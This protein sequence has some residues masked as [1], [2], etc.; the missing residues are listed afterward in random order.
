M[1]TLIIL[2]RILHMPRIYT[3]QGQYYED[4]EIGDTVVSAGRTL[5]ESDVVAF[6]GVSGD[7]S[8]LHTN[9]E[10][11]RQGL[12]GERIAHGLLGISMASGLLTQLGFIEGT[13]LA[14]RE[15]TWKFKRP[16]VIGDTIRAEAVVTETRAMRRL[17][18]GTVTL[19][20]QVMNQ[21]NKVVQCGTWVLLVASRPAQILYQDRASSRSKQVSVSRQVQLVQ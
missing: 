15:M 1:T 13:V 21:I 2:E 4:F 10:F 12:F 5:T 9:T 18:G 19:C 11:A 6:A 17:G 8:Q 7:Y 3:R 16:I 20:V 14:F